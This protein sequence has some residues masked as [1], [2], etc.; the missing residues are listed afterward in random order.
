MEGLEIKKA[1]AKLAGIVKEGILKNAKRNPK[2]DLSF[3]STYPVALAEKLYKKQMP[4]VKEHLEIVQ[5]TLG[6]VQ[7]EPAERAVSSCKPVVKAVTK[8][9]V[10]EVTKIVGSGKQ[11][12]EGASL[13]MGPD[14]SGK[15]FNVYG[16]AF[17]GEKPPSRL[18]N[19]AVK[20]KEIMKSKSLSMIEAS[21]YIKAN[22][23]QY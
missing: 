5:D 11:A 10:K 19:R 14:I 23:I 21:K 17:G 9:V 16:Q 15:N 8:P 3:K 22:N 20:I 7:P 18:Q 6:R 2:V 13:N 1:N 12:V 4:D